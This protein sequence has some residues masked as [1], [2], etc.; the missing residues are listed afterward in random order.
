MLA[1]C[2][3]AVVKL[4][5]IIAGFVSSDINAQAGYQSAYGASAAASDV[6]ATADSVTPP[7]SAPAPPKSVKPSKTE[8]YPG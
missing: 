1:F 8:K 5:I 4:L 7:K 2:N 3:S 6:I